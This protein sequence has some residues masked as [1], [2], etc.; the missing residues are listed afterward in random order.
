MFELLFQLLA[1]F[2]SISLL[3]S[4]VVSEDCADTPHGWKC[5]LDSGHT[6]EL[7]SEDIPGAIFGAGPGGGGGS[8]NGGVPSGNGAGT[9]AET[10]VGHGANGANDNMGFGFGA[11]PFEQQWTHAY[12][13]N[14]HVHDDPIIHIDIDTK[15]REAV[16]KNLD[17]ILRLS[18]S[19]RYRH[20]WK[21]KTYEGTV[22]LDSLGDLLVKRDNEGRVISPWYRLADGSWNPKIV[23]YIDKVTDRVH[24]SC[25]S[26]DAYMPPGLRLADIYRPGDA[27]FTDKIY[28]RLKKTVDSWLEV[29]RQERE[30]RREHPEEYEIQYRP[31]YVLQQQRLEIQNAL[32]SDNYEEAVK[33]IKNLEAVMAALPEKS[34]TKKQSEELYNEFVDEQG[35]VKKWLASHKSLDGFKFK[36]PSEDRIGKILRETANRALF[37]ANENADLA[38]DLV[39]EADAY[40][41]TPNFQRHAHRLIQQANSL[42]R[43]DAVSRVSINPL[44]DELMVREFFGVDIDSSTFIGQEIVT[45]SNEVSCHYN[46]LA[47]QHGVLQTILAGAI[48]SAR[49]HE[50]GGETRLALN[51]IHQAWAVLDFAKGFT[52]GIVCFARDSVTGT[53]HLVIHP[54]DSAEAIAFALLNYDK[55]WD[56]IYDGVKNTVQN[57]DDLSA[58]EKGKLVAQISATLLSTLIPGGSLNGLKTLSGLGKGVEQAAAEVVT[59]V[60]RTGLRGMIPGRVG[61]MQQMKYEAAAYH[62]TKGNSIKSRGPKNGQT[63]LDT[64]TQIKMTSPRR[65]GID[66]STGE[67]VVFDKTK[68]NIFHGH[69]RDWKDL[70]NEMQNALQQS[71]MV[72]KRGNI[73]RGK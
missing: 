48:I 43:Q 28:G 41:S 62:G 56:A 69:V 11:P 40:A 68:D 38:L 32:N 53:L 9:G 25:E 64:S 22:T 66:H 73:L 55:T 20:D 71:G 14:G 5:T 18:W 6:V 57:F 45:I 27:I 21:F 23:D 63:A 13:T 51:Q 34:P 47:L 58:E 3:I 59:K 16:D 2:I 44:R 65:V 8:A 10:R 17:K 26:G 29:E 67:F 30:Y 52:K 31:E 4:P 15:N 60:G 7:I 39:L 46:L 70:T 37:A 12:P 19:S 36:H 72:D 33:K 50:Q 1:Y 49:M 35:L 61:S 54:V 24:N 42:L